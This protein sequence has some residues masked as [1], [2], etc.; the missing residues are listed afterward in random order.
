[1][2]GSIVLM[3]ARELLPKTAQNKSNKK[4][5]LESKAA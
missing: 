4:A 1:M 3:N 5:L 2:G